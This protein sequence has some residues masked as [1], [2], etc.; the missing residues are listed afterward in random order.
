MK[1]DPVYRNSN[2]KITTDK[3]SAEFGG[4]LEM[5]D[6]DKMILIDDTICKY[7]TIK[8]KKGE[9][10]KISQNILD[11]CFFPYNVE[12]DR[13]SQQINFSL[14]LENSHGQLIAGSCKN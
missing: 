14:K 3:E 9:L 4:T 13:N 1:P 11:Q 6:C 8:F 7:P 2:L 12:D 5:I 10:T